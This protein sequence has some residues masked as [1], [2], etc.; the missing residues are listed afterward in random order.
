MKLYNTLNTLIL[1]VAS[2]DQVFD[3]IK[4]KRVCV[5]N[6]NGD[7]PGGKGLRVIEPVAFGLSKKGNAVLRAWDREG[8]SHTAYKGEKPLPGWRLFRLDKMDFIRPTQE[9]FDTPKSDYNPNGDKSMERVFINA[10]F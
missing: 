3:A 10:V 4:N 9:T 8:A 7:E 5:I 6:Y 2:R 1:E